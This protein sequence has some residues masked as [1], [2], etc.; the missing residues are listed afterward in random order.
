MSFGNGIV[1]GP[2]GFRFGAV[3]DPCEGTVWGSY[4]A[5]GSHY[6]IVGMNIGYEVLYVRGE[7]IVSQEILLFKW[8]SS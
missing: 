1:A 3:D 7:S 6:E 5:V 4:G 8:H 2:V